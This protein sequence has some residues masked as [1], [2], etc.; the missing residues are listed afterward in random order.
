MSIADSRHHQIFPVLSPIQ[1]QVARHFAYT[2][3][4]RY[5]PGEV[6]FAV[7]ARQ[8]PLFLVLSGTLEI[9][10]RDG[11]GHKAMIIS[12]GPGEFSGEASELAGRATLVEG[13]AGPEGC[14][15]LAYD[16]AELRALIVGSAE[17]GEIIMRAF[18]LRCVLLIAE[19]GAG[20]VLLGR[21]AEPRLLRIEG[22]L[23]RNGYPC[24]VLDAENDTE[25]R[26]LIEQL[27]LP[28]EELPIALCPDGNVLKQPSDAHVAACVGITP[29]IDPDQ[30]FDVAV[31]GAGPAGLACAVYAAS[32]GL[33]VLVLDASSFGGQ[34]GASMRIENYLGFPTGI[35]GHALAARAFT[36][37]Q[38]FG[39]EIAIPVAVERL[40]TMGG[41]N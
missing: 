17:V 22:F 14:E 18:I 10:R 9:R 24:T 41:S 32:E 30:V 4:R 19:R 29:E 13:K 37:A 3:S 33:S 16:P 6:L 34:A 27:G 1:V 11:A 15:A 31:V 21:R 26:T 2:P 35:S 23:S 38:K 8:V 5:A 39:A 7:G 28:Q 40:E 12:H 25:A 20:V 36:Q